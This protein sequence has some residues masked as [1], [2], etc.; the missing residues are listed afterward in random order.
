MPFLVKKDKKLLIQNSIQIDKI[1]L[2]DPISKVKVKKQKSKTVI[3]PKKKKKSKTKS[4][5]KSLK[6]KTAPK[7]NKLSK[8][9]ED[10]KETLAPDKE[11]L[12]KKT[13]L[14]GNKLSKGTED[15]KEIL[16]TEQL[17]TISLYAN[18]VLSQVRRQWNLP[19]YLTNQSLSAQVE[20][21]INK[22][23]QIIDKQ[24]LKESNN[25]QFDSFVLKAIEGAEPFP[26]P[27][28]DVQKIIKNG[29]VLTLSSRN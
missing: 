29:I 5:K 27:P 7:D 2:P 13:A 10:K 24:I 1:G 15:G 25:K 11:P 8:K 4:I 14:K 19:A 18:Q 17:S 16:T 28:K 20:I 9:T 21:R 26:S 3:V 6:K 22:R 12:K 23:G